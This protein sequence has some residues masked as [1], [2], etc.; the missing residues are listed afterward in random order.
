MAGLPSGED[1]SLGGGTVSELGGK[2]AIIDR[3]LPKLPTVIAPGSICHSVGPVDFLRTRP[4]RIST[5]V[6]N[7]QWSS[8]IPGRAVLRM[9]PI[10]TRVN[11]PMNDDERLL[12]EI[13]LP[14]YA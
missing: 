8:A 1:S 14:A 6:R 2:A 13:K 4:H 11:S 10:S 3:A 7:T 9:W 12:D 5:A